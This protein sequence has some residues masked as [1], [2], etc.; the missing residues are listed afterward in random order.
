MGGR[1]RAIS[2][3]RTAVADRAL[4]ARGQRLDRR[5]SRTLYRWTL[6]R[7]D[8]ESKRAGMV[9]SAGYHSRIFPVDCLPAVGDRLGG[10]TSAR[11]GGYNRRAPVAPNRALVDRLAGSPAALL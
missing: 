1:H 7:N 6:Y 5:T 4:A 9:L 3:Y 10:E 2:S 11:T 8:R